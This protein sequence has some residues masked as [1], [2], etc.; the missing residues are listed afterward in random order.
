MFSPNII[1]L[2]STRNRSST[3]QRYWP[4]ISS[5][6]VIELPGGRKKFF[7]FNGKC[8]R[9]GTEKPLLC[10]LSRGNERLAF[11]DEEEVNE[12]SRVSDRLLEYMKL[13]DSKAEINKRRSDEQERKALAAND[14]IGIDI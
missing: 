14:R 11:F 6:P 9:D 7:V 4:P 10:I 1:R 12:L 2:F 3:R 13:W 8:D 5:S